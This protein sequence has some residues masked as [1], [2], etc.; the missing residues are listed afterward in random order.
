MGRGFL[1]N[2]LIVGTQKGGTTAL[3]HFLASHPQIC[4]AP[5]KEAHFFDYDHYCSQDYQ[6]FFPN[7]TDQVAIG[8]AT[9]IYM[10]LPWI[11]PRL[12]VYNPDLKLIV[13][14]RSPIARAFSQYQMERSRGWENLGFRRALRLEAGRLAWA[15]LIDPWAKQERSAQRTHSY[16]DR[17]FY[18]KQLKNLLQYFP[19]QNLLVLRSEELKTNHAEVLAEVYRF[20]EVEQIT[21]PP[22]A[23]LLVG[24]YQGAIAPEDQAWLRQKYANELVDLEQLL[25]WNLDSWR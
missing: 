22:P 1:V 12:Y 8:E 5:C 20:L 9:P 6:K 21:P 3:A 15:N 11:A 2:F 25:G 16:S 7:Y 24:Q 10:Y 4:M 14:L 13:L 19:R 17:G 18:S 23:N